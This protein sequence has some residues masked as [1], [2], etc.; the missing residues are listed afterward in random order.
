MGRFEHRKQALA[1]LEDIQYLDE[2][3]EDG[4]EIIS[5]NRVGRYWFAWLKRDSRR[6]AVERVLELCRERG[7]ANCENPAC[8]SCAPRAAYNEILNILEN[9]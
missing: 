4:W 1:D 2:L 7:G 6:D 8:P 9:A 5:I 3:T